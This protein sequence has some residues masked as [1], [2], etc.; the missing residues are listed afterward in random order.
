MIKNG[1]YS[2]C[3]EAKRN[4]VNTVGADAINT[5]KLLVES[6]QPGN[7]SVNFTALICTLKSTR[8]AQE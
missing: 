5:V 6:F 8:S 2:C 7:T 1:L 3:P 4:R